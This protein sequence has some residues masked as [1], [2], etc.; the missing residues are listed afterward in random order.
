MAALCRGSSLASLS[1]SF[2]SRSGSKDASR[3]I[4]IDPGGGGHQA[5]DKA[6]D[7]FLLFGFLFR[8]VKLSTNASVLAIVSC[9]LG[10]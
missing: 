10:I 5:S 1:A 4:R 7:M 3:L 2:L 6:S 8:S 9:G